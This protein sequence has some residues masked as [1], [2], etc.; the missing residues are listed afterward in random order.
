[1]SS[2]NY[3]GI[4]IIE[5]LS[6]SEK[7]TGKE[8]Y[9]EFGTMVLLADYIK[10]GSQ[11]FRDYHPIEGKNDFL[12]LLELLRIKFEVESITPIIHLEMHGLEDKTGIIFKNEETISWEEIGDSLRQINIVTQNNLIVGMAVCF[13]AHLLNSNHMSRESPFW[14]IIGAQDKINNLE[15]PQ[16]FSKLY[17]ELIE[18]KS[19]DTSIADINNT[20]KSKLVFVPCEKLFLGAI[21]KYFDNLCNPKKI[22]TWM[23]IDRLARQI[24]I[25]NPNVWNQHNA[26]IFAA[27]FFFSEKNKELTY[28]RYSERYFMKYLGDNRNRFARYNYDFLK[29]NPG[30]YN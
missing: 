1:M 9:D 3:S 7:K 25:Q 12:T 8:L 30:I 16:M 4:V 26:S 14:G 10:P 18:G 13:G 21:Q 23:R 6:D 22:E 19:V 11:Y 5:S 29:K 27:N 20:Y 28:E 15:I 17:R 24:S 2:A